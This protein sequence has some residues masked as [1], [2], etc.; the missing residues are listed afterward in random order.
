MA[1][2]IRSLR[3]GLTPVDDASRDDL[4]AGDVVTVSAI[5]PATTYAWSLV[6]VPDGSTAVFSGD[7]TAVSP[8][9]FTVDLDG[10][11]L[12]RL[13][14]NAGTGTESAQ[15]VRLRAITVAGLRLVA[16]GERRDGTG[17]IPVDATPEGW[18]N[19][20]NF[21]LLTLEAAVLAGA[22]LATV[23][24]AGN[25]TGGTSIVLTSG[26][27]LLGESGAGVAGNASLRGGTDTGAGPSNG[28]DV[29][30]RPGE[31]VGGGTDGSVIVRSADGTTAVRLRSTGAQTL[32]VGTT[33]PLVYDGTTGKLTVPG[34][35]DPTALVLSD[36][37]AGT[38]LYLE[39]GDGQ[40]SAVAPAGK[41]RIR[42]NGATGQWEQSVN[43]GVYGPIGAGGG[44][45]GCDTPSG[46]IN[47]I[48]TVASFP[49]TVL[50][51]GTATNSTAALLLQASGHGPVFDVQQV[52]HAAPSAPWQRYYKF[53]F[54]PIQKAFLYAGFMVKRSADGRFVIWTIIHNGT[55]LEVQYSE[56]NSASS[57][58]FFT[59]L[60]V[61]E[62][63]NAYFKIEDDGV[64]FNLSA[65][66]AGQA[67]TYTLLYSISRTNWLADYDLIGFGI[68]G[69]N[70]GLPN[71]DCIAAVQHYASTPPTFTAGCVGGGGGNAHTERV[72]VD[73]TFATPSPI[74]VTT[75]NAG[76][77]LVKIGL[78]YTT[79][80]DDPAATVEVGDTGTA[81]L[82]LTAAQSAPTLGGLYLNENYEDIPVPDTL[83]V[84]LTPGASTQGAGFF[85]F[86]LYRA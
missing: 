79:P 82:Y 39:S 56:Y 43:G 75:L 46:A 5:D 16:A 9:T 64:N 55:T 61:L 81:N 84:T 36:P 69:F 86:D 38:N 74:S 12:V 40:T 80:F 53:E 71:V 44:G 20:Q 23:L 34:V 57:R 76:D 59:S 47:T 77:A 24:G 18:A 21:N 6:F 13:V 4:V 50:P 70:A 42:Y 11:Y 31:G 1:A 45:G 41:G 29:V 52:L 3:N 15:Y 33:F 60:G 30:L 49:T 72:R 66:S 68:D 48:P 85:V 67:G 62:S 51:S 63:T 25:T 8:G 32:S 83:T 54:N 37:A 19:D 65:S 26:D 17:I 22:P 78:R 27:I 58:A 10:P 14:T 2:R 73:F 7:P 28:G 35:L